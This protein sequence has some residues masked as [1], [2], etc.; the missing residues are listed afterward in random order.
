[1]CS[2]PPAGCEDAG[3]VEYLLQTRLQATRDLV[4]RGTR[5]YMLLQRRRC[6]LQ[7][8][9][10]SGR[11]GL[12]PQ[13]RKWPDQPLEVLCARQPYWPQ[14]DDPAAR[15]SGQVPIVQVV[16]GR[17]DKRNWLVQQGLQVGAQTGDADERPCGKLEARE[18][19]PRRCREVPELRTCDAP[20]DADGRGGQ[21]GRS[22]AQAKGKGPGPRQAE[23]G[24]R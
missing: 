9:R 14:P 11:V 19:I 12:L 24:S 3:R 22:P 13:R 2:W 20:G 5:R 8:H 18:S 10:A 21:L 15:V 16:A 17:R 7:H 6:A 23:R 4:S 1:G